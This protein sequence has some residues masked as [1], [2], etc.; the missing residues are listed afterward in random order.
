MVRNPDRF[1]GGGINSQEI[2]NMFCTKEKNA[3]TSYTLL[4]LESSVRLFWGVLVFFF[5]RNLIIAQ[6]RTPVRAWIALEHFFHF[7]TW[8]LYYIWRFLKGEPVQDRFIPRF[9]PFF[10]LFEMLP[11]QGPTFTC[12]PLVNC[13]LF[14]SPLIDQMI[15]SFLL[16]LYNETNYWHLF[17]CTRMYLEFVSG[18]FFVARGAG[19][20]R[21]ILYQ[22]GMEPFWGLRLLE[23]S[24]GTRHL[25]WLKKERISSLRT[26]WANIFHRGFWNYDFLLKDI[27][28]PA[29]R[30]ESWQPINY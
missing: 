23:L 21:I 12:L 26:G 6:T 29:L 15:F 17:F 5:P 16:R 10:L 28:S 9:G 13:L 25:L 22:S 14:F 3:R 8:M 20:Y 24:H 30:S 11:I 7:S 4:L 19:N 1:T 27:S 2:S 18:K